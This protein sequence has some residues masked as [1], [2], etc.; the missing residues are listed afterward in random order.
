MYSGYVV[1]LLIAAVFGQDLSGVDHTKIEIV[2]TGKFLPYIRTQLDAGPATGD[3][4]NAHYFPGLNFYNGGRYKEA[5]EQFSYVI[6]RPGYLEE[7]PRQAGFLSTSYYLRGMIYAHH[8]KG[9][10]RQSMARND[11]E[12]A[13][14]WNSRNYIVFLELSR[15]YSGLGF[16][17][18][19][20]SILR[21]LLD[22]RPEEEIVRHAQRDLDTLQSPK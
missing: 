7:N 17:E 13:L 12:N 2:N 3:I 10:G 9:V 5:E 8:A 22:R 6:L 21:D 1:L 14:K 19:A 11:F 15:L 20:V 4:L 16:R 18:Q